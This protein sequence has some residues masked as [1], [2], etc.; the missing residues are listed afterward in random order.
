MR[1]ELGLGDQVVVVSPSASGEYSVPLLMEQP[2]WLV[3][4]VPVAPVGTEKI[5]PIKARSIRVRTG[6][7]DQEEQGVLKR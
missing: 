6:R 3:G 5:T 2:S 1:Y 7:R 4:Y